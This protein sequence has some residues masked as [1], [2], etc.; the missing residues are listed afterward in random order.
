MSNSRVF[1]TV[2]RYTLFGAATGLVGGCIGA[3]QN[4]NPG[5]YFDLSGMFVFV[6]ISAGVTAGFLLG[7][8][9]ASVDEIRNQLEDKG[10]HFRR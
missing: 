4:S 2:S 7:L 1:D 8:V 5:A 3:R 10:Q 9:A 6:G